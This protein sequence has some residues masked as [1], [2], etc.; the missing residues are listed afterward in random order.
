MVI[1]TKRATR[2]IRHGGKHPVER[3]MSYP[4]PQ[5]VCWVTAAKRMTPPGHV[6]V[7]YHGVLPDYPPVEDLAPPQSDGVFGDMCAIGHAK[8]CQ[9]V[10]VRGTSTRCVGSATA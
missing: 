10:L 5:S 3:T 4:P 6:I 2:P 8:W 7:P 9:R 1:G